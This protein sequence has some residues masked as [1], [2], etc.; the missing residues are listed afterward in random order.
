MLRI[1]EVSLSD[2]AAVLRLE[3]R[4]MGLWVAEVR[5]CCEQ[6]LADGRQLTLDLE[7][8]SFVARDALDLF[9]ELM[10]RQVSFIN[11]SPFLTEQLREITACC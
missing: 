11:C 1:S 4:V 8:V 6:L 2:E 9:K 10:D 5:K 3:G 7:D